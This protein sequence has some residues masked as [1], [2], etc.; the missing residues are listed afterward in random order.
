MWLEGSCIYIFYANWGFADWTIELESFRTIFK[1][2]LDLDSGHI[3]KYS[4]S[5]LNFLEE[6]FIGKEGI[7][8]IA[9]DHGLLVD[10]VNLHYVGF[11]LEAAVG[12]AFLAFVFVLIL[13]AFFHFLFL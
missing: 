10:L 3:R 1:E 11:L 2:L 13:V 7:T 6:G 4:D 5:L 8:N 9:E 12:G